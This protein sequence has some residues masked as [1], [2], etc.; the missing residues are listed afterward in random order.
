MEIDSLNF[1]YR[2]TVRNAFATELKN[3]ADKDE[4][5][6]LL[7]GDIGNTLFDDFKAAYPKR[8]FNCGVAE[9]NM[10]SMAAGMAASG[11]RPFVYTIAS[12]ATGRCF[13]QIK[14]DVCYQNLPVVI[15]GT[16][17]G[18]SYGQ[19]GPT[20]HSCDDIGILRTIPN[21]TI[22]CPG[23]PV[24]VKLAMRECVKHDGPIYLRLGK[25]GEPIVHQRK[26]EPKFSFGKFIYTGYGRKDI[27][28]LSTGNTLPLA[29]NIYN[30]LDRL[31]TPLARVY[32]CHTVKPLDGNMMSNITE[33]CEFIVT[34]EEHNL[35]GGLASAVL[36]WNAD[37]CS[38]KKILRFGIEDSFQESGSQ[39]YL[40][41][42]NGLTVENISKVV[43]DYWR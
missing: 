3:I 11:L 4:R 8:F 10:V 30:K 1:L 7:M 39:Q 2:C 19:L 5:V 17:A 35:I 15:V 21:I 13:E 31:G 34:I 27:T 36:E 12:F 29:M 37:H 28:I 33:D 9:Q 22:C 20:H 25:Q 16:G 43:F 42:K 32:S 26:E 40:R 6:V 24:E 23:D 41:E 14:I 38:D 18:L